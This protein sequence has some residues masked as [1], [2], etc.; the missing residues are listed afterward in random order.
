MAGSTLTFMIINCD[1]CTMRDIAC[2]DCVV[3]SFLALPSAD[4]GEVS[5]GTVE[6][7]ERLSEHGIIAPLRFR[8]AI[9]G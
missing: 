9:Q 2:S 3:T 4:N 6:A 8:S 5:Q 1:S 7:L